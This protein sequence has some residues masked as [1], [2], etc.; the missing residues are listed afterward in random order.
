MCGRPFLNNPTRFPT[1]SMAS[2]HCT[3]PTLAHLGMSPAAFKAAS[4]IGPG[5]TGEPR[6]WI[7]L[8]GSGSPAA[9]RASAI[10]TL[11]SRQ[12]WVL[13]FSCHSK[14]LYGAMQYASHSCGV[15]SA[16][17]SL[18]LITFDAHGR[19]PS[20]HHRRP[21]DS[22]TVEGVPMSSSGLAVGY[23]TSALRRLSTP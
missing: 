17:A 4:I 9:L 12:L 14:R 22:G 10:T 11:G 3:E 16:P 2:K 23:E 20:R 19:L 13:W 18:D 7:L 6:G 5:T 21:C 1:N 15:T 8:S